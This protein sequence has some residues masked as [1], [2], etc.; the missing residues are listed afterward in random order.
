VYR[1]LGT[2]SPCGLEITLG[3]RRLGLATL[4]K[5]DRTAGTVALT[6][7]NSQPIGDAP[8]R[9]EIGHS[10]RP[11][12]VGRRT[13]PRRAI[14]QNVCDPEAA[15]V[16]KTW[17]TASVSDLLN[18]MN[19]RDWPA[20]Q[21]LHHRDVVYVSP[22]SRVVGSD[23]VLDR[24]RALVASAPDLQFSDLKVLDV[25]KVRLQATFA[26][27]QTGTLVNDLPTPTGTVHGTGAP[28]VIRTIQSVNFDDDGRM[29]EVRTQW[30]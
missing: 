8:R 25:D 5:S 19:R 30:E 24:C 6:T 14:G 28:F 23:M 13:R 3:D 1:V 9:R 4:S 18:A 17:A 27:T 12:G 26:Y 11:L 29:T 10:V 7:L 15:V 20:F 2:C 22:V 16:W 21:G